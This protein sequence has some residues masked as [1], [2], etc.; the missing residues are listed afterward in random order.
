MCVPS[1]ATR[2]CGKPCFSENREQDSLTSSSVR[3]SL[4]YLSA[5][6]FEIA[7]PNALA[8]FLNHLS[9]ER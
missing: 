3:A 5:R 4:M 6:L 1:T 9:S 2:H 8:V 7:I